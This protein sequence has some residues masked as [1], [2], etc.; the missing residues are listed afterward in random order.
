MMQEAGTLTGCRNTA[1]EQKYRQIA[2]IQTGS[3][4]YSEDA[5]TLTG[6]RNTD[7]MQEH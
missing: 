4:K 5:G 3:R 6:F 2:G 1:K 7:R